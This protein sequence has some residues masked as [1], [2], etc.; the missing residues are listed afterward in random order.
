WV[1]SGS[2]M[3]G[4]WGRAED[5]AKVVRDSWLNTGDL[6]FMID[7]ELYIYG[8]AKDVLV[9]NGKKHDPAFVE[10]CLEGVADLASASAAVFS[11]ANDSHDTEVLCVLTEHVRQPALPL[12]A[13]ATA[14]REAIVRRTGL[15]PDRVYV[16]APGTLPRT[17]SGKIQRSR[18][19][20]QWRQG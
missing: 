13:A 2:L 8:R 19:R 11:Y 14:A 7:G 20:T 1:S 3:A 16:V 9:I 6:G 15:I 17:T 18:A 12:A 4:Y 10:E 5:T